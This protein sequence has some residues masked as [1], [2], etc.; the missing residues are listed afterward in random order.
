MFSTNF[1]VAWESGFGKLKNLFQ[2]HVTVVFSLN[3][4]VNWKCG[5]SISGILLNAFKKLKWEGLDFEMDR[6]LFL[7]H[8]DRK[9]KSYYDDSP[10]SVFMK[11]IR[12][13]KWHVL[14]FDQLS[15]HVNFFKWDIFTWHIK[16]LSPSYSSSH[17]IQL[18]QKRKILWTLGSFPWN[19]IL[20]NNLFSHGYFLSYLNHHLESFYITNE[21]IIQLQT[22]VA[23]LHTSILPIVIICNSCKRLWERVW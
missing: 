17:S 9:Q 12:R 4:N 19:L 10:S 6:F 14:S 15:I 21:D 7:K 23:S 20:S 18:F 13:S 1:E 3:H 8:S 2:S 11:T 22:L 5:M 16:Q